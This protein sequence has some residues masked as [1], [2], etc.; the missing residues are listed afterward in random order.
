MSHSDFDV[1]T[2]PSMP[3]LQKPAPQPQQ[4]SRSQEPASKPSAPAANPPTRGRETE[5][6]GKLTRPYSVPRRAGLSGG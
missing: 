2:G 3:Q 5:L 1:V 6:S 4:T